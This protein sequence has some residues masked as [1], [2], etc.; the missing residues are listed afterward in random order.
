M[1]RLM[2][3]KMKTMMIE[4]SS[5]RSLP[6]PPQLIQ[7]QNQAK[8]W[9][10]VGMGTSPDGGMMLPSLVAAPRMTACQLR[11]VL[12]SWD[13][14][15]AARVLESVATGPRTLTLWPQSSSLLHDG[16][17]RHR[18]LTLLTRSSMVSRPAFWIRQE[19]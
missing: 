2:T 17:F 6:P 9:V 15:R 13:L 18:W 11:P 12:T 16:D 7:R 14:T 4:S 1:S 19:D 3:S 5:I 8:N 10:K